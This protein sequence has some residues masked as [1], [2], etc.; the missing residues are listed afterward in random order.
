MKKKEELNK[1]M[2]YDYIVPF[3]MKLFSVPIA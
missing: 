1:R 3:T 2:Q